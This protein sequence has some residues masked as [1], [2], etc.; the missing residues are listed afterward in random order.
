MESTGPD[1]VH[2]KAVNYLEMDGRLFPQQRVPNEE[3]GM[4]SCRNIGFGFNWTIPGDGCQDPSWIGTVFMA[5]QRV[6]VFLLHQ[7]ALFDLQ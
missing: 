3:R 6:D 4:L 2:Y 5:L 1:T 7:D